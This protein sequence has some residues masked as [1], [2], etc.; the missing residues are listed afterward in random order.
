MSDTPL[1]EDELDTLEALIE[2]ASPAPWKA[3]V[4][5]RDH[6]SGDTFIQLGGDGDPSLPD[7]Y[8]QPRPH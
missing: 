4:E 5:G 6:M 7:M 3:W 8:V 1:T 2:G